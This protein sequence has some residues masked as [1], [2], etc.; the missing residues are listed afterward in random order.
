MVALKCLA[1][2]CVLD[3][4]LTWYT[5]I[6]Q[7][8]YEQFEDCGAATMGII[9][10]IIYGAFAS[11]YTARDNKRF[12]NRRERMKN[13]CGHTAMLLYFWGLGPLTEL[14][15]IFRGVGTRT[16][17]YKTTKHHIIGCLLPQALIRFFLLQTYAEIY[18]L[19][20]TLCI[21]CTIALSF[22]KF[23]QS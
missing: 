12:G 16:N 21:S 2:G 9:W 4:A 7:F 14:V 10:L 3:L 11:L 23:T 6:D 15:Q 5:L 20:I 8:I 1:I 22:V 17:L 18:Y 13:Q 19:S